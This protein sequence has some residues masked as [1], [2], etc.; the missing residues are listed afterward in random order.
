MEREMYRVSDENSKARWIVLAAATLGMAAAYGGVS[1][2]SILI[3]PFEREFGWQRSEVSLAYTLVTLGAALG[4]LVAGRLADR[5]PTGSI[6]MAGAAVI[7]LGLML[8]ARQSDLRMVQLIYLSVGL[9]G[10]AALYAPLLTAVTHWFERSAGFAMGI[11]MAGGALGQAAVPP[12]FQALVSAQGWRMA[13]VIFG[14]GYVGLILPVMALVRKPRVA[15]GG[16]AVAAAG[17][18]V[19]PMVSVGLLAGAALFCCMLMAMPVLHLVSFATGRGL[20][21]GT[22]AGLVTVMMLAGVVGRVATGVIAD[23][24]GALTAYALVSAVQTGSIY[25]FWTAGSVPELLAVAVVYGLGFG[26]VMTALVCAVSAAVPRAAIG[27]AMAIVS[28]LAWGGMGAGGY[29]AGFC[30]DLTGSYE[31]SFRMAVLAG[32][33]NLACLG[34]LA[35]MLRLRSAAAPALAARA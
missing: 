15:A 12:L 30:F 6:A 29:Q 21:E 19:P 16:A 2:I 14:A 4:G 34:A 32:V 3:A 1:T 13:C 20:A 33:A 35:A 9:I 28:L 23:R 5:L 18:S 7:G 31:L 22:A 8:V 25:L 11:V 17:W 26:G 10:F 24:L 27:R